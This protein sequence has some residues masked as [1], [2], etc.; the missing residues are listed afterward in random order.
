MSKK[1]GKRDNMKKAILA[2]TAA[3]FLWF[4]GIGS[5]LADQLQVT[6]VGGDSAP[7]GVYVGPYQVSV[8]GTT[9]SLICDDY[10][11]DINLNYSWTATA[12]LGSDF[13]SMKFASNF[14]T[15]A[16]QAY[17]EIFYLAAQMELPA[18]S[19]NIAPI[20]YALWD[21]GDPGAPAVTG[22]GSTTP[23]ATSSAYWL[24]QAASNYQTVNTNDFLVYTPNPTNASQELI[25][26]VSVPEA[27][28]VLFAGLG[29]FGVGV[30]GG[31]LKKKARRKRIT[32]GAS[33]L[34]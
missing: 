24:A 15:S 7:Y 8:N 16:A 31:I 27:P 14:G 10:A 11:T 21:I 12:N 3:S 30:A 2:M 28:P 29:L 9:S 23:D 19:A 4:S 26:V 13:T 33:V 6:G 1:N 34:G 32:L 17:E 22:D 25:E 18:N 5:A 20:Q